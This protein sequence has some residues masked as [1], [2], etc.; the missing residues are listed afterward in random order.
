MSATSSPTR[1]RIK[2]CGMTR[3][4]DVDAAVAASR[5]QELASKIRGHGPAA[6]DALRA[7]AAAVPDALLVKCACG[8]R[9]AGA[10][11]ATRER[12]AAAGV[13]DERAK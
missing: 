3:E 12:L 5:Q 13:V 8:E 2:L 1:T 6:A 10:R 11:S 9:A 4:Q 7:K